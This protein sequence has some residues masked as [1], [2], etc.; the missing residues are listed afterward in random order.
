MANSTGPWERSLSRVDSARS[1]AGPTG[2][3]SSTTVW[4]DSAPE[5]TRTARRTSRPVPRPPRRGGPH[6]AGGSPRPGR[7]SRSTSPPSASG[8]TPGPSP[9]PPAGR[10]HP[11]PRR[12]GRRGV[13]TQERLTKQ[14]RATLPNLLFGVELIKVRDLDAESGAQSTAE[15]GAPYDAPVPESSP[16]RVN[17]NVA[18][19]STPMTCGVTAQGSPN[20]TYLSSPRGAR[21]D[22]WPRGMR[23]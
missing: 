16:G 22:A 11:P 6:V 15:A 2:A 4:P 17:R 18:E 20:E 7:R 19:W 23:L 3:R 10:P 21:L 5:T 14:P 1:A 13:E 12:A 8:R 9:A